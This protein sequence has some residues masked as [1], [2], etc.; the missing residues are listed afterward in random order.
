MQSRHHHGHQL[1]L[2][3]RLEKIFFTFFFYLKKKY[4]VHTCG[5]GRRGKWIKKIEPKCHYLS[6]GSHSLGTVALYRSN[7]VPLFFF[8]GKKMFL[9]YLTERLN[10]GKRKF[11]AENLDVFEYLLEFSTDF[12]DILNGGNFR[13]EWPKRRKVEKIGRKI[14]T[15]WIFVGIFHWFWWHTK[16]RKFPQ[17]MT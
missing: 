7:P 3:P 13:K 8:F 14:L 2:G 15:F 12:G 6:I 11:L 9:P 4:Q 5:F 16:R 10:G 1:D 17:G